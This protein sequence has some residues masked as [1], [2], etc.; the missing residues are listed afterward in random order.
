M[1]ALVRDDVVDCANPALDVFFKVQGDLVD[2]VSLEYQIFDVTAGE[3]GVQ[4]FPVAIG[5]RQTVNVGLDCPAAGAG[6]ITLGRYVADGYTVPSAEPVG[7]HRIKWFYQLLASSPEQ[8]FAEDFTVLATAGASTGMGYCTLASLRAQGFPDENNGGL[9]DADL[10]AAILLQSQRID[11]LTHQFFEPRTLTIKLDG[12]GSRAMTLHL[13]IISVSSVKI[14]EETLDATAFEVYNRHLTQQLVSPDDRRDPRIEFVQQDNSMSD[15]FQ[16]FGS[17]R[18]PRGQQNVEIA[19]TF[20]FTDPPGP[21]GV[22]PPLI[23]HATMLLVMRNFGKVWTDQA[24]IFGA[25]NQQRLTS[26]RTRDQQKNYKSAREAG[27]FGYL[28]GDPEIDSI[29]EQ[30]MAPLSIGDTGGGA[31]GLVF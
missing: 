16:R 18:F 10:E 29:L 25:Q 30:Y 5:T 17:R 26:E 4:V 27:A 14:G 11:L 8:D 21:P 2:V 1:T 12:S 7:L 23:C 28:T 13:P 6:R 3:P 19:G 20:G 24:A 15:I 9:S 22:T 31:G